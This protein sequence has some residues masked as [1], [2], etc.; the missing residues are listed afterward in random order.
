MHHPTHGRAPTWQQK[1]GP[2]PSKAAPT[3]PPQPLPRRPNPAAADLAAV[4][5]HAEQMKSHENELDAAML[6]CCLPACLPAFLPAAR[7]PQLLL[8][9]RCRRC[10][11]LPATARCCNCPLL[12]A[13]ALLLC[14]APAACCQPACL[15]IRTFA[16]PAA[17]RASGTASGRRNRI[18]STHHARCRTQMRAR[19]HE[20]ASVC[21]QRAAPCDH[22]TRFS[23]STCT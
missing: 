8:Q 4:Q 14:A 11:L 22:A 9:W 23:R 3:R 15:M 17:L 5:L 7:C 18:N 16:L 2:S 12:P 21:K 19:M 10:C 1:H 6:P 20:G 13:T